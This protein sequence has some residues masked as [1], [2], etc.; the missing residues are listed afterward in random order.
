MLLSLSTLSVAT[1]GFSTWALTSPLPLE[2]EIIHNSGDILDINSYIK[3]RNAN[4]FD[5]CKD[6]IIVNGQIVNNAEIT[7]PFYINLE[8]SSDV[9]GNHLN[10]NDKVIVRTKFKN[11]SPDITNIFSD[12]LKSVTISYGKN[13]F[14]SDYNILALNTTIDGSSYYT[15]DFDTNL[16]LNTG[17]AYFSVKYSFTFPTLEEFNI[18]VY[19][20]LNRGRFWFNFNAEIAL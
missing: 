4:I 6:G 10:N 15:A 18:N 5:Y 3:Y 20:K 2:N 17:K 11:G 13:D 19:Q 1:L 12:F 14:S 9:I 7:V 8:N 16:D